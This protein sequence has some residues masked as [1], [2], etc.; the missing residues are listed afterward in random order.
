MSDALTS[1]ARSGRAGRHRLRP[2]PQMRRRSRL[3]DAG[4]AMR[5]AQD[6]A[7]EPWLPERNRAVAHSRRRISTVTP[8]IL[9]LSDG[10]DYGDAGKAAQALS[11]IGHLTIFADP[12][13]KV[14]L[15]LK[16]QSNQADGFKVTRDSRRAARA[17]GNGDVLAL[18]DRGETLATSPFR[19]ARGA[20]ATTAK[21]R[22]PLEV[23]NETAAYRHRQ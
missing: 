20:S 7:P 9:W 16:P 22:L 5:T 19:F 6:L 12:I 13:G 18:G 4:K 3:L 17:N 23:R 10:L 2:Q 1:A 14:P 21:L 15:A 8:Q 11:N